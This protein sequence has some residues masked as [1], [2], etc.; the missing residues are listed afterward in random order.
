MH[1]H[2]DVH[3]RLTWGFALEPAGDAALQP[4]A[5]LQTESEAPMDTGA[6]VGP[7][8]YKEL[9]MKPISS[10]EFAALP[11]FTSRFGAT[12]LEGGFS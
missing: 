2:F 4:D 12:P 11:G 9:V 3:L 7:P 8:N 6:G 5:A 10:E 1:K